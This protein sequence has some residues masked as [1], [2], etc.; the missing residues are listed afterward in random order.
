MK[1]ANESEEYLYTEAGPGDGDVNSPIG[2]WHPFELDPDHS[3]DEAA[4][5]ER[6][7]TRWLV[8]Q[9]DTYGHIYVNTFPTQ[10]ERD[11]HV[12]D[13]EQAYGQ[14][15]MRLSDEAALLAIGNYLIAAA[16]VADLHEG[17]GLWMGQAQRRA[18]IDVL[19]FIMQNIESIRA[20]KLSTG[21]DW[22]QVGIDFWLSRTRQVQDFSTREGAG[23]AGVELRD[24]AQQWDPLDVALVAGE[25][26][27]I[28]RPNVGQDGVEQ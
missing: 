6:Y 3:E 15:D 27:F 20:W 11:A 18:R 26:A 25:L 10:E 13:L 9:E 24:A 16:F 14:W 28:K 23:E 21:H 22:D 19:D 2:W 4:A 5:L 1:F 17:T 8:L 7:A 12:K